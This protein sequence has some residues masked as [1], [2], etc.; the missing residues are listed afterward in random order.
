M[1]FNGAA[2]GSFVAEPEDPMNEG[3]KIMWK[4]PEPTEEIKKLMEVYPVI[5]F[6]EEEFQKWCRPWN[7]SLIISMLG[8]RLRFSTLTDSLANIWGFSDFKLID[9][10]NNHCVCN[11]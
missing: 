3:S 1:G 10:P 4:I 7:E 6:T 11:L 8:A 2:N 9:L 5:P